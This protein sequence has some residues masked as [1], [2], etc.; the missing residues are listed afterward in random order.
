MR[1]WLPLRSKSAT[2]DD[3]RPGRSVS[4]DMELAHYLHQEAAGLARAGWTVIPPENAEW[5]PLPSYCRGVDN[6]GCPVRT[7]N[8]RCRYCN[9]SRRLRAA[10]RGWA[11]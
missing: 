3:P 11:A 10:E 4:D 2:P 1:Q 9:K 6:E 8:V 5:I 7:P